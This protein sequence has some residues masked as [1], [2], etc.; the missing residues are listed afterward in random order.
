MKKIKLSLLPFA[1]LIASVA[2]AIMFNRSPTQMQAQT[3][4]SPSFAQ[5]QPGGYAP[6]YAQMNP[7]V[8]QPGS[9]AQ[10]TGWN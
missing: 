9:Y 6:V 7:R 3:L 1:L 2:K 8:A 10:L 5:N 4:M